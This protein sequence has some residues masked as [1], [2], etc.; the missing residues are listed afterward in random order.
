M[1]C[2]VTNLTNQDFTHNDFSAR[3]LDYG[4]CFVMKIMEDASIAFFF[5]DIFVI[6]NF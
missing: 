6:V 1:H 3:V 4:A 5:I 2:H